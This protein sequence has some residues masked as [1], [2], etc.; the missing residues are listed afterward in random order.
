MTTEKLYFYMLQII[1]GSGGNGESN[2][3]K[4]DLLEKQ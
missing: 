1:E 2:N 3:T 4:K